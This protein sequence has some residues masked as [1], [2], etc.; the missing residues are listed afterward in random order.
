MYAQYVT[1]NII[2]KDIPL[3]HRHIFF[4]TSF[5]FEFS[6]AFIICKSEIK[7]V[8]KK[9]YID[10]LLTAILA[11]EEVHTNFSTLWLVYRE[12]LA[13]TNKYM[14]AALS[15]NCTRTAAE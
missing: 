6:Q 11:D 7:Y 4:L 9:L 13:Q 10:I 2:L 14:W 15:D 8:L 3:F 5:L 1:L 12:T